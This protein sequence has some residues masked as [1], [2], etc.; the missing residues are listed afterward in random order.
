MRIDLF[1]DGVLK[2]QIEDRV[3]EFNLSDRVMFRGISENI[4]CK[5]HDADLFILPSKWEGVPISILEAM[6]TGIPI[7]ASK[8]GG[9]GNML[10]DGQSGILIDPAGDKLYQAICR[11][12]QDE[13][14]RRKLGTHAR[15]MSERYSAKFMEEQ[16]EALYQSLQ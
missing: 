11:L 5:L 16:Y 7:I 4:F 14:Y 8:V 13:E 15:E 12:I 2:K 10:I 6:G 1:G 3:H 9:V